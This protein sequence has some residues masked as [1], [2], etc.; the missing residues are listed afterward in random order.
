MATEIEHRSIGYDVDADRDPGDRSISMSNALIKA[1]HGLT[2]VEK[3]IV[4][5]A[6]SKLDSVRFPAPGVNP[7]V[8]LTASEYA[9]T[10][11][12]DLTTAYEQLQSAAKS[13]YDRSITFFEP[14]RGRQKEPTRVLM[15][16][17]GSIKYHPGEA[18]VELHFW[19][20]VVPHLMGLRKQFTSYKLQQATALRSGYSWRLLE[21]LMRFKSSG[22][23]EYSIEE[24]A[25]A[26]DATDKQ[27][28]D[29]A[30]LRTKI[31][32]PAIKELVEKDGWL[33]EYETKRT[34]RKV[35]ALRFIFRRNPQEKLL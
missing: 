32:E 11:E 19:H 35:Q 5:A 34:G 21:L 24:F 10:F 13:L 22:W 9:D 26:M 2:L 17:V 23:A 6:V 8:C 27:R 30:K 4:M 18:W 7:V 14:P 31:L 12:L 33:I 29:F 16:W 3:R 1:G 25:S 15:R 28:A 20:Q